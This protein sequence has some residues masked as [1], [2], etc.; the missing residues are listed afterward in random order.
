[1]DEISPR[2]A[3]CFGDFT[4]DLDRASLTRGQQEVRLRPRTFD[5]LAYLVRHAG[6]LVPKQELFHAV[7]GEV[8]VTDD[9]LVQCLVEIRRALAGES[10]RVKTVRARGYLFD[11]KVGHPEGPGLSSEPGVVVASPR[12]VRWRTTAA[13]AVA[14]ALLGT[15]A[16]AWFGARAAHSTLAVLPFEHLARPGSADRAE[17]LHEDVVAALGQIDPARL[18][19]LSR[20]STLGYR[21]T[22][23]SA[24]QIGRD[25]GADYLVDGV[26]HEDDANLRLTFTLV[27]ARDQMQVWIGTFDHDRSTLL[28]LQAE[29]GRAVAQQIRM[30]LSREQEDALVRRQARDPAAYEHYLRGRAL[31]ARSNRA[32]LFAA[33]DAFRQATAI[34]P[35]YAL[36]YAG[37]ADAYSAL[38]ITSD[39]PPLEIAARAREAATQAVRAD[40]LLAE[41]HAALGWQEFWFGWNWPAAEASLRRATV[42]DPNYANAHRW[43]GHVLSNA[44]RHSEALAEMAR[45][46]E[47][48]P[49]SPLLR[50]LSAQTAYHA[51]DFGAAERQARQALA[52][53]RNLWAGH[54]ALAQALAAQG[55]LDAAL[56]ATMEASRLAGNAKS[57]T[58]RGYVLGLM[59]RHAEAADV[60]DAVQQ[61]S[62]AA[63]VPPYEMSVVYAGLGDAEGLFASLE[64]AFAVR[65]ANLVFLPVDPKM[66]PFRDDPRFR[67]LLERCGFRTNSSF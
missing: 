34:D 8:A 12:E 59:G 58:R 7:W 66:D 40:P 4:L 60:L 2:R 65:D 29:L 64:K 57:L 41:A 67:A 11:G 28:Y 23:K 55:R 48:D 20:R 22:T 35:D 18:R 6:R 3:F 5:V 16:W 9:S 24:A 26:V 44:G 42:L 30:K 56:A 62:R 51:R 15:G 63:F 32:A 38:P 27:R 43:L 47:L 50:V 19:V 25:L 52:I 49:F 36:A 31:W 53:D 17:G 45:A 10:E 33:I 14:M 13:A 37:L 54:V 46:R 61:M 21:N 1:M 39:V